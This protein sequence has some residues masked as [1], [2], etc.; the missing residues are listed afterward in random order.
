MMTQTSLN[1]VTRELVPEDQ[2]L[3]I[4]KRFFGIH[5]KRMGIYRIDPTYSGLPFLNSAAVI[6]TEP[7]PI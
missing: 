7:A 5:C 4:T 3:A 6:R 1:L 2:R